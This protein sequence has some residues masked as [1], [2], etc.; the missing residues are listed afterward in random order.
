M[1]SIVFLL[2]KC[3]G[4]VLAAHMKEN[5][6]G[7]NSENVDYDWNNGTLLGDFIEKALLKNTPA[8]KAVEGSNATD[9]NSVLI[10]KA[11]CLGIVHE[12]KRD[13]TDLAKLP[14]INVPIANVGVSKLGL[15]NSKGKFETLN[16]HKTLFD[17]LP[18]KGNNSS[19]AKIRNKSKD[20]FIRPRKDNWFKSDPT[21]KN[22][23]EIFNSHGMIVKKMKFRDSSNKKLL[24]EAA[25]NMK[26]EKSWEEVG[27][28]SVQSYTPYAEKGSLSSKTYDDG[29]TQAC[30]GFFG[31]YGR[32]HV[33][34]RECLIE[35][36]KDGETK[37]KIDTDRPGCGGT[38]KS[39]DK[40]EYQQYVRPDDINYQTVHS[41]PNDLACLNSAYGSTYTDKNK[42]NIYT[43][44]GVFLGD[45]NLAD[46]LSIDIRCMQNNASDWGEAYAL[47][48][49]RVK[50]NASECVNAIVFNDI[51]VGGNFE[52]SDIDQSNICN[53]VTTNTTETEL[54]EG[55]EAVPPIDDVPIDDQI[56]MEVA[57]A[58]AEIAEAEKQQAAENKEPKEQDAENDKAKEQ[59]AENDKAKEQ[60]AEN[61][62]AKEQDAENVVEADTSNFYEENQVF[63]LTGGG[64][65][66]F[67]CCIC[68]FIMITRRKSN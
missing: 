33:R 21:N 24:T 25:C 2:D 53:P 14:K 9:Y 41:Y 40:K 29:T 42:Q 63:I 39:S 8:Q 19:F 11:C 28:N 50:A 58:G 60:D 47:Q 10:K 23:K 6:S 30:D 12:G 31:Y 35:Y 7:V 52:V 68:V 1:I 59:D 15:P 49:H 13:Q 20:F 43:A 4:N 18:V 57:E 44:G 66:L 56:A 16:D 37:Y 45:P 67:V 3:M 27:T 36:K 34:D 46:P 64:I 62:K 32:Q 48:S 38:Y 61:D 22:M 17:D 54:D 65:F 55:E 26:R 5:T 51:E